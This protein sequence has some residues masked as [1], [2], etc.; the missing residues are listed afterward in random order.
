MS[1]TGSLITPAYT[2]TTVKLAKEHADFVMGFIS[3]KKIAQDPGFI[4]MTPGVHLCVNGDAL[5]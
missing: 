3:Q 4:H 2:E 1:S 5:D